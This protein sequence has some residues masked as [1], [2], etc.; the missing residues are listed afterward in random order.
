MLAPPSGFARRAELES[1]P[2]DFYQV[3][4]ITE[5]EAGFARTHDG[6]ALVEKLTS[7]GGF[8]VTDPGRH[9]LVEPV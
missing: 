2:F 3:V 7:G 9:S 4:G 5:A 6:A 8:P 1:G